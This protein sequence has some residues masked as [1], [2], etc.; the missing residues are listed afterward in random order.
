MDSITGT[1]WNVSQVSYRII[2]QT[3]FGIVSQAGSGTYQ[4]FIGIRDNSTT[5]TKGFQRFLRII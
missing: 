5:Y 1:I 2:S 4:V 3:S